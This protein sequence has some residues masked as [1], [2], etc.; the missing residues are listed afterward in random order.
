MERAASEFD[1]S[2]TEAY[3][4]LT[5]IVKTSFQRMPSMAQRLMRRVAVHSMS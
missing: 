3:V 4:C 2:G 1:E 5:L